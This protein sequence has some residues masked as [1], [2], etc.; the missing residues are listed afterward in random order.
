MIIADTHVHF[1]PCYDAGLAL[2]G[3][4]ARLHLLDPGAEKAAFL[5]ERQ[6]CCFFTDLRDGRIDL[7]DGLTV[8]PTP[9]ADAL[10]VLDGGKHEMYLFAGRQIATKERL[11]VLT[12]ASDTIIEDGLPTREVIS[13]ALK[14]GSVPVLAWALGKW[15]GKRNGIVGELLR[16]YSNNELLVGDSS[17]R[18]TCFPQ[19][20]LI[21]DA[22]RK[23]T[24]I[25]AG[26]DPLPF[27]GDE[28]YMGTYATLIDGSINESAPVTSVRNILHTATS[29]SFKRTGTRCG[30]VSV[31]ARQVKL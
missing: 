6:E 7:P 20:A 10:S 8:E 3:L 19:P 13:Q 25:I 17:M 16:S 11:E 24:S 1:Y 30:I 27:K 21:N 29:A 2:R 18:P 26:S 14:N 22:I 28:Q 4:I 12:L 15:L 31:V 9:E 23:G 5:T